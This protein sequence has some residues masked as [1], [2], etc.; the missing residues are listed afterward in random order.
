MGSTTRAFSRSSAHWS[1]TSLTL[2]AIGVEKLGEVTRAAAQGG[3]KALDATGNGLPGELPLG[4][5]PCRGQEGISDKEALAEM[6]ADDPQEQVER[7]VLE[8]VL[9]LH[10][11]HLTV[12][13]LILRL[14]QGRDEEELIEH[15]IRD[16]KGSGLLRNVADVLVPTHAAIRAAALLV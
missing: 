13:E 4:E 1:W 5:E 3:V 12:Q 15:S 9:H 8:E 10:P 11:D 6:F 16:L 14:S 2:D 7:V